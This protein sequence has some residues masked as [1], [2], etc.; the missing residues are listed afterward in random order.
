MRISKTKFVA[1][2]PCLKRLQ[3]VRLIPILLLPSCVI[4][5]G[6]QNWSGF[7][8]EKPHAAGMNHVR[9]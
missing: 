6:I 4:R 8:R 9:I 3:P 7:S 5:G 1:G 2:V